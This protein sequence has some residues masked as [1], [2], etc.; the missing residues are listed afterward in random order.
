MT[1]LGVDLGGTRTGIACSDA[2][3]ILASPLAVLEIPGRKK[4]QAEI[5]RLG[6]ETRA[7]AYV[8]GLPLNMDGTKGEKAEA[9]EAFADHLQRAVK[10]PVILQD[11]RLTTVA[12]HRAL[13]AAGIK[14]KDQKGIIDAAAAVQIL[15]TYLDT[16]RREAEA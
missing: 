11:E 8:I 13:C 6:A 2:N 5:L 1:I 15:Q 9:A 12:A 7:E 4:L 3:G 14:S 10:V 16:K